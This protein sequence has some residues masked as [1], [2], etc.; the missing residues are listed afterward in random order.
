MT[1]S[2]E[3]MFSPFQ[4]A[5]THAKERNKQNPLDEDGIEEASKQ[6]TLHGLCEDEKKMMTAGKKQG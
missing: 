3:G 6:G 2:S 4:L 5:G 1:T